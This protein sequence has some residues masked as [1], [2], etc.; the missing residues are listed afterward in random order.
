MGISPN[1][2]EIIPVYQCAKCLY[3][4]LKTSQYREDATRK[5]QVLQNKYE[6]TVLNEIIRTEVLAEAL[7]VLESLPL[8]CRKIIKLSLWNGMSMKRIATKLKISENT[9]RN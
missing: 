4:D 9:V 5:L 1:D 3:N 6:D 2:N 7:A 8:Q